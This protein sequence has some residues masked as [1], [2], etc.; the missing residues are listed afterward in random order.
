LIILVELSSGIKLIF[1]LFK[2]KLSLFLAY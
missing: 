1:K 2:I